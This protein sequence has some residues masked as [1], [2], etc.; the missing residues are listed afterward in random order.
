[1]TNHHPGRIGVSLPVAPVIEVP[2]LSGLARASHPDLMDCVRL[3]SAHVRSAESVLAALAAEVDN[4]SSR[5][6]GYTGLA[7][8]TGARGPEALVAQ[9]TGRSVRDA[10]DLIAAGRLM[11]AAPAWFADVATGVETGTVSVAAAAAITAGLGEP[12]ATVAADDLL[13]AAQK[14][15]SE[16]GLLPPEK[17][18]RRAREMRDELD[19]AGVADREQALRDKRFLKL[20]RQSDGMTRLYGLLDPESAALVTDAIDCVTAPRRHGPRFVDTTEK[21]RAQAIIDDPR[22][23]EQLTLDALVEMVRIAGAADHGRVFGVR[24]PAVRV[25]VDARDLA[26]GEG[27]AHLEGQTASVSIATAQ[28][29]VCADGAVPVIYQPGGKLDVGRTQRLFT[30]RQRVAL[31]AIWGGCA[32]PDCD[33]P[34]SW[35]E[36]HHALPDSQGGP[37]DLANGILLCRF[38]H[39]M[40]HNNGWTIRPPGR[41]GGEWWMHPPSGAPGGAGVRHPIRLVSKNPVRHRFVKA[42]AATA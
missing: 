34:P 28:R 13:D 37:T 19:A 29:I 40:I 11:D 9:L 10:R 23:T 6:L 7:V 16:V 21:A 26:T 39:M 25:H 12:S 32:H 2:D 42:R 27:V 31:A 30:D 14:L 35:T 18:A 20:T 17:A 24:K 36:A 38:H 5:D 8:S 41:G 22:T 33:L 3:W 1:M 4:R 15:T